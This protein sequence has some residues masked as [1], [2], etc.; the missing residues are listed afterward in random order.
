MINRREMLQAL[1]C[2]FGFTALSGI[3][4]RQALA[5]AANPLAPKAPHFPARAKRVIFM[6]MQGAPSQHETFDY[7]PELASAGG[8][9]IMK[10]AFPFVKSGQSGLPI[11]SLFP[12][13]SKQADELC[14]LNGMYA[15]SPAHPQATIQM[16]TGSFTFVRPSMGAWVVYG[17]GTENHDLPGFITINPAGQG[18]SQNFG[19]AFLPAS[20]QGTPYQTKTGKL[21]NIANPEMKSD[22]QRKQLDLI[23][24]LNQDYLKKATVDPELEGVIESYEMAFRM[25]SSVPGVLDLSDESE[26]TK[27]MYG[28]DKAPTKDFGTQCLIA[29]RLAEKGVRFIEISNRNWDHHNNLRQRITQNTKEIDQPIAALIADLKQRGLLQDTL[30]LWGGEFGRTTTGQNGDGRNHNNRGFT[31]WMA[32]GGVKGG[33]RWGA[34]DAQTGSAVSGK[35][36][37]H[38]MHATVLH[39]LGLDHTK[40]TYRYGGRDFRLTDVHGNVVKEI[41][42]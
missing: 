41:L 29:R 25:Q 5:S 20:Y 1:S 23:Q 11:S 17:L 38:D 33:L 42:A 34:T 37:L 9:N 36:H 24:S 22:S 27:K 3:A 21:P 39:L 2:G 40:L 16:H 7:N 28:V 12:E 30:L 18:G 13:L 14:L 32:G 19:S 10:P 8:S 15:D 35:V 6:Y 4:T 31:M 26:A